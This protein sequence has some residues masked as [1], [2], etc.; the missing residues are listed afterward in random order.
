MK[1]KN[2]KLSLKPSLILAKSQIKNLLCLFNT[3]AILT[4]KWPHEHS[5]HSVCMVAGYM[6]TLL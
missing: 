2:K 6:A 1:T 3:C 5:K 4:S